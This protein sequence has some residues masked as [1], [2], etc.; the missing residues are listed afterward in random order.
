M[1]NSALNRRT[2]VL[3]H[4]ANPSGA[5]SVEFTGFSS[6]YVMYSMHIINLKPSEDCSFRIRTSTDGGSSY[7]SGSSDYSYA[8]LVITGSGISVA[9]DT[10]DSELELVVSSG[11]TGSNEII[12][13]EVKFF[14]LSTADYGAIT[15]RLAYHTT[16]GALQGT[17]GGGYRRSTADIDAITVYPSTGTMTGA[18]RIYGYKGV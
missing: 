6:D 12:N 18:I 2:A 10:S 17:V 9:N 11:G 3:T 4:T 5:S 16:S 7:D 14:G 15:W 1:A 13:G 8:N